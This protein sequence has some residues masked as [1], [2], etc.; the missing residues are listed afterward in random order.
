MGNRDYNY[1][2]LSC[3]LHLPNY[4][5]P[6]VIGKGIHDLLGRPVEG[7]DVRYIYVGDSLGLDRL[8]LPTQGK[9]VRLVYHQ[10]RQDA[11]GRGY[12]TPIFAMVCSWP[13]GAL[14]WYPRKDP[15]VTALSAPVNKMGIEVPNISVGTVEQLRKGLSQFGKVTSWKKTLHQRR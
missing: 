5:S 8:A 14:T 2:D 1:Y 10:L 6:E 7:D 15:S 4:T 9:S 3:R 11:L 13:Q 12:S